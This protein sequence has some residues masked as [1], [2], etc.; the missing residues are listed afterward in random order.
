M[1]RT[2]GGPQGQ[3]EPVR[4]ISPPPGYDPR[5][6]QSLASYLIPKKCSNSYLKFTHVIQNWHISARAFVRSESLYILSPHLPPTSTPHPT[7]PHHER[8]PSP[9]TY[10]FFILFRAAAFF[11]LFHYHPQYFWRGCQL[12]FPEL[13]N[14]SHN[15][16]SFFSHCNLGSLTISD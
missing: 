6:V 5:S 9:G 7:P 3:S 10:R 4:K 16:T 2:L 8:L 15:C 1:Y 13:C 11:H 12:T 14:L